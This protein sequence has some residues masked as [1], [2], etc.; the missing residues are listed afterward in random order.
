MAKK[1][2]QGVFKTDNQTLEGSD[3]ERKSCVPENPKSLLLEK[4]L[5]DTVVPLATAIPRLAGLLAAGQ[6]KFAQGKPSHVVEVLEGVENSS[7]EANCGFGTRD[8][9]NRQIFSMK[10]GAKLFLAKFPKWLEK[11]HA[12]ANDGNGWRSFLPNKYLKQPRDWSE[13]IPET[14]GPNY[15]ANWPYDFGPAEFYKVE[16]Y[17]KGFKPNQ[18]RETKADIQARLFHLSKI[19]PLFETPVNP[20]AA[21]KTVVSSKLEVQTEGLEIKLTSMTDVIPKHCSTQIYVPRNSFETVTNPQEGGATATIDYSAFYSGYYAADSSIKNEWVSADNVADLAGMT[22]IPERQTLDFEFEPRTFTLRSRNNTLECKEQGVETKL[23]EKARKSIPNS[24][25]EVFDSTNAWADQSSASASS[26]SKTTKS[27]AFCSST[28]AKNATNMVAERLQGNT[29]SKPASKNT[30]VKELTFKKKDG[31][32]PSIENRRHVGNG[33]DDPIPINKK[34]QTT[35]KDALIGPKPLRLGS[36]KTSKESRESSNVST[37]KNQLPKPR[38]IPIFN[39]EIV[40]RQANEDEE[41]EEMHPSHS[42]IAPISKSDSKI[43]EEIIGS[44][45]SQYRAGDFDSPDSA[46]AGEQALSS[47]INQMYTAARGISEEDTKELPE[48]PSPGDDCRLTEITGEFEKTNENLTLK[49]GSIV[50]ASKSEAK[51]LPKFLNL[52]R[53][54]ILTAKETTHKPEEINM[55]YEMVESDSYVARESPRVL[56]HDTNILQTFKLGK[57]S[58]TAKNSVVENKD[59]ESAEVQTLIRK[60]SEQTLSQKYFGTANS[61]VLP[62]KFL[63]DE[64]HHTTSKKEIIASET[65]TMRS[66]SKPTY[67]QKEIPK[68]VSPLPKEQEPIFGSEKRGCSEESREVKLTLK[69]SPNISLEDYFK[70]AELSFLA[71][72]KSGIPEMNNF[73]SFGLDLA[74]FNTKVTK[75]EYFKP[76]TDEKKR[77]SLEMELSKKFDH[78]KETRASLNGK[79]ALKNLSKM[80]SEF[81]ECFAASRIYYAEITTKRILDYAIWL[82]GLRQSI[83][84][85]F[86]LIC[87]TGEFLSEIIT[88]IKESDNSED[89]LS[90]LEEITNQ[91]ATSLPSVFLGLDQAQKAL[92]E[93]TKKNPKHA[94]SLANMARVAL[95]SGLEILDTYNFLCVSNLRD[96]SEK[97]ALH[98]ETGYQRFISEFTWLKTR[99]NVDFE[100]TFENALNDLQTAVNIVSKGR[101]GVEKLTED[102][103][104]CISH[105]RA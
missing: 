20:D 43:A 40:I 71:E 102:L 100:T 68:D 80:V 72:V 13:F 47:K 27:L 5:G 2:N 62:R 95:S 16:A 31:N 11:V 70:G 6:V 12:A 37:V 17:F 64:P 18:A 9:W 50:T 52:G 65:G 58:P 57:E 92:L 66:V 93:M 101:E 103:M 97:E 21:P 76:P 29:C 90:K 61:L 28:S 4:W 25:I 41:I 23:K 73:S 34:K 30:K 82:G 69:S 10:S 19:A 91:I 105:L 15:D 14:R 39:R 85:T 24:L 38:N 7:V 3:H 45:A 81:S 22:S 67:Y 86:N 53:K 88:A 89:S 78:C 59:N 56:I 99:K 51:S 60:A 44:M 96:K 84:L 33:K 35:F 54:V 8:R 104:K 87:S 98:E 46:T 94:T 42:L 55:D 36:K 75:I 79:F 48:G 1:T 63:V 77:R 74:T 32:I 26:A 83:L 49:T